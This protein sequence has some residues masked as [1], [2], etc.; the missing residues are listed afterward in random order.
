M[1]K[2][3]L[4]VIIPCYNESG[5]IK[6]GVLKN[7]K[8]Y[9]TKSAFTWE[10]LISDDGSSDES[11]QLVKRQIKNWKHFRL[12]ENPHKG[13]PSALLYGIKAAKGDFVLFSD[14]DQSTPVEEFDKLLPFL[15]EKY[16]VVIGS[17]G[18]KRK[19]FPLY[20]KLGSVVFA[21]FRKL[22]LLKDINDTQCGFKAFDRKLVAKVFPELQ[23]FKENKRTQGW[24][25]TSYDVELLHIIKK[26]GINIKEV[27]VDWKSDDA[28]IHKGS[29]LKRYINESVEMFTQILRVKMND[30]R[31]M[32][33]N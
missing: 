10:V 14:M 11:V 17:R 8:K 25:V 13:K 6:R 22:F 27:T 15:V 29:A 21:S 24:K 18:L 32:Y 20:R 9:L 12:L 1:K 5:N 4:S 3:F 2:P 31:G 23:F 7:I 16:K 28:S 33:D 19:N 30:L 26:K